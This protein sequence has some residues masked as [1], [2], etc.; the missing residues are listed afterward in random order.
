MSESIFLLWNYGSVQKV[1]VAF[2]ICVS[3][4]TWSLR[5][6]F[7]YLFICQY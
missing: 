2:G 1:D 5:F 7:M 4:L 6:L 3:F